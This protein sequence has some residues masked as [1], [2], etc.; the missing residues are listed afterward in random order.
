MRNNSNVFL[1]LLVL[2]YYIGHYVYHRLKT[3]LLNS[4]L[5]PRNLQGNYELYELGCKVYR[6]KIVLVAM[7]EAM[8]SDMSLQSLSNIFERMNRS[9]ISAIKSSHDIDLCQQSLWKFKETVV[10]YP[11]KIRKGQ[12]MQTRL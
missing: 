8:Q 5:S 9:V 1:R 3:K 6:V 10:D 4:L 12:T 11:T 2:V 7:E